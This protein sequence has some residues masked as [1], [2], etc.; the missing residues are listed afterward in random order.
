M[1]LVRTL[2]QIFQNKI[3]K[4]NFKYHMSEMCGILTDAHL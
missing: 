3:G 1:Q 2:G 4:K